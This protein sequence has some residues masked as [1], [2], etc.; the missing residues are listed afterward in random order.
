[1]ATSETP[2]VDPAPRLDPEQVPGAPGDAAEPWARSAVALV[3]DLASGAISA[4]A[5]VESHIARIE[6]VDGALRAVVWKRYEAARAEAV[7]ADRRRAAGEPL[8]ALH[9]LP[10]TI[11]ECFDL[12]GSPATFGVDALRDAR[13]AKDDRYVAALR[14]AGAIVLGKTNVS[15]LL[16][17]FESDNPVYGMTSNPWDLART[18]G[19]SSGG[20]SAIVAAGGSSLGLGNDLGGSV[21]LPAAFCGIV[22]FKPTADRMPDEGRGSMSVGEQ[23][24]RSQ[25]GV[26]GREVADV[27][28]GMRVASGG[29]QPL[30]A[31]PPLGDPGAVD[32]AA[33]RI[34]WF[35]DDGL[36][37]PSPVVRRAVREAADALARRGA[38]VTEWRPPDPANIEALMFGL[39]GA[40]R[41]ASARRILGTSPR[42]P[43]IKLL[44]DSARLPRPA[45]ELLLWLTRRRRMRDVLGRIGP[46]DVATYWQR[47][48]ALIDTRERALA[49]LGDIDVILSPAAPLP[50]LRHGASAEVGTLGI[51]TCLYNVLGWPAGVVPWT[52]VRA[53]EE[54]DRAPSKD[55]CFIAAREAERDAAGLPIAVQIAARPWRDHVAL[56]AMAALEREAATRPDVP[57]TPI[58]PR[59]GG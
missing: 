40:D 26:H 7:E 46:Y 31:V 8:G 30:A 37:P 6:A 13:A 24:I 56:A 27:A 10:I 9:G 21:R 48:E 2:Q 43:R 54:S 1:M 29:D 35:A 22:G 34:G 33:L 41:F 5:A 12:E 52:T 17:Y 14:R 45:A 16:L 51:Y 42:D 39:L 28:L 57:R 49:A 58:A 36:F 11:K 15:Q 3:A 32:V 55:P 18:P 47:V 23:A 4:V 53:G 59:R 20:S 19:G 25:V 44:E 38:R 50:P